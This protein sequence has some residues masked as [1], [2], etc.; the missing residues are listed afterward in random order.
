MA[1]PIEQAPLEASP[2]SPQSI[3][4]VSHQSAQGVLISD[5]ICAIVTNTGPPQRLK[6]ARNVTPMLFIHLYNVI[7]MQVRIIC[8]FKYICST[9]IIL[10]FC[11]PLVIS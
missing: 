8:T 9:S 3:P 11:P 2:A 1:F 4:I 10:L 5:V 7:S 6:C